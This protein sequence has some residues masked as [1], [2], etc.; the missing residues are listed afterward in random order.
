MKSVSPISIGTNYTI[1]HTD[2]TGNECGLY[3]YNSLYSFSIRLELVITLVKGRYAVLHVTGQI[4]KIKGNKKNNNSSLEQAHC[5]SAVPEAGL[6]LFN[7]LYFGRPS[8]S[9]PMQMKWSGSYGIRNF[10]ALCG[11]LPSCR[12]TVDRLFGLKFSLKFPSVIPF[13]T[14]YDELRTMSATKLLADIYSLLWYKPRI[15]CSWSSYSFHITRG[16]YCFYFIYI[17]YVC[18]RLTKCLPVWQ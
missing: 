7:G 13:Q 9:D 11:C 10:Y 18:F 17:G 5:K 8:Q 16:V 3:D 1:N 4:N 15:K 12:K 6:A 14:E 2:H